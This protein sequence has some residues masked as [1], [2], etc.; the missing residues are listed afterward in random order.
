MLWRYLVPDDWK[1][2]AEIVDDLRVP[3]KL[4]RAIKVLLQRKQHG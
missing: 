1:Q 3:P 2:L 4:K